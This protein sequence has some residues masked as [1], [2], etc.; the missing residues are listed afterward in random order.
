MEISQADLTGSLRSETPFYL[1]NLSKTL[2]AVGWS[3][4]LGSKLY[5][6]G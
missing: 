6:E 3:L 1:F 2:L 4:I 5:F